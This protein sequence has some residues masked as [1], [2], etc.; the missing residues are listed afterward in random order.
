MDYPD[1]FFSASIL[2]CTETGLTPPPFISTVRIILKS[3]P[4]Q[5]TQHTDCVACVNLEE[6]GTG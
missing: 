6:K 5:P 2:M 1:I 4:A 3:N